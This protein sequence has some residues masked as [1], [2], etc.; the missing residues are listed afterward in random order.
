MPRIRV[1][2]IGF[3]TGFLVWEGEGDVNVCKG[4]MHASVHLLSFADFNEIL[5]IFKHSIVD[6][7]AI[8]T[9]YM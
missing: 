6:V 4:C 9:S 5:H 1:T 3:H 7:E 2:Y 8:L